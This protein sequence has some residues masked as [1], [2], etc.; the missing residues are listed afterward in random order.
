M[1]NRTNHLIAALL[2]CTATNVCAE[3][4]EDAWNSAL[5]N[6]HQIKSAKADTSASEQQLQSAQGQRLPDLNV[7]SGYT[8]YSETPAAKTQIAGQTAQFSTAQ[9]GSVKAQ[10]IASVP[11][12]TSGRISHNINAAEASLQA[13]QSNEM[14]SVLNIKM[15]VAEA[16]IAVLRIESLLQVALSHVGTLEQHMK[17]VNS[18]FEQGMVARNDVLAANVELANAQQRVTL[19]NNQL[20]IAKARYNQLLDRNLADEVKLAHQV[21]ETPPGALDELSS[22]ALKQRPELVTLAQQIESLG[23]QAQSVKAGLLPQVAV[24]GGYQYQENR[25]QAFEGMWMANVGMDWK[26]FDGSSGH[27][28]D[29]LTRQAMALKEQR[30]DLSSMIALQVRQA[31]LDIQETQK[32][33]AVTQQAIA[34]ADENLKVTMDRYQQ[35]L[36]TNTDVLKAEDLRTT[37]HDNFNNASYDGALAAL[38]LRRAVGVL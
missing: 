30:D 36:S 25:Y 26:L 11:I 21:P 13:V 1:R 4:L 31:W 17:D 27:R 2:F 12:F 23:Q 35:G 5:N 24:N 18:L 33:I 22:N 8:Q 7:S 19:T 20:D 28:S 37:T 34:Q 3:T 10:A 29:A 14:T 38:H 32:R 15:Q 16:Y 6:N 9:A